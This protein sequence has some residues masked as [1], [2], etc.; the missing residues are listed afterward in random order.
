MRE[1]IFPELCFTQKQLARTLKLCLTECGFHSLNEMPGLSNQ[2]PV[3]RQCFPSELRTLKQLREAVCT[4]EKEAPG[5]GKS[6]FPSRALRR[7]TGCRDSPL[8]IRIYSQEVLPVHGVRVDEI[9][10][11]ALS[12]N[13]LVTL[14]TKS[15]PSSPCPRTWARLSD[16]ALR[17]ASRQS[18]PAGRGGHRMCSAATA[19]PGCL[20]GRACGSPSTESCSSVSMFA[21]KLSA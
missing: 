21:R 20:W 7:N 18:T 9:I 8:A 17:A 19:T 3:L 12:G 10:C 13:R 1:Q 2:F 6:T 11:K 4:V 15:S 5:S 14:K 16:R